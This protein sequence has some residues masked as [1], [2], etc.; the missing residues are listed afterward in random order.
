MRNRLRRLSVVWFCSLGL[1]AGLGLLGGLSG[2][3][4]AGTSDEATDLWWRFESGPGGEPVG[5]AALASTGPTADH[6]QGM[7]AENRALELDGRGAYIRVPDDGR[8]GTLKFRQGDPITLEAW[9]RSDAVASGRNVYIVGKGRTHE[10]EARDNQNYALRLRG[11]G[12]QARLS[13]LFRSQGD[14][15]NGSDWHRWTSQSGFTPDGTW[16]HVAVSYRF[17]DPES[18]RGFIDGQRVGGSWDMG[19]ATD[20]PP[21]VDDDALWIG[22]SM[23]GSGSSSFRGGIDDLVIARRIVPE[24]ELLSRRIPIVRPPTAPPSGIPAD[25]VL[26]T[27]HEGVSDAS[28][29]HGLGDAEETWRQSAFGLVSIP[30]PYARGG[31]RRDWDGAVLVTAMAEIDLPDEPL[32]WMLRAGGLSRL[33]IGET[34]VAETP[35]HLKNTGGHSEV[36]PYPYDDPWLRPARPGHRE[37]VVTHTSAP[38]PTLVTLQTVIGGPNLRPE[39]GEILVAVRPQGQTEWQVLSTAATIPLTDPAWETFAW[40]QRDQ[41]RRIDDRRRRDAASADDDYWDRRHQA[42]RRFVESLP[43]L[44]IPEVPGG[45]AGDD[46]AGRRVAGG[47]PIDAFIGAGLREAGLEPTP[48]SEDGPFLRRVYLDCVGVPPDEGEIARFEQLSGDRDARRSAV[49]E[50]LLDDPRTADHWT[51]YWL[52]V[53]AENPSILKPTLNNT[54]PFRWYIHDAM[55]DNVPIDRWV[56]DL[57]R[58]EGSVLGG[59]PA[60]FAMATE[61]DVPMAA[62]AH[63]LATAFLGVNMKCARCHDAPYHDWTQGDLFSLAAM[64]EREP[65]RIPASSSVPDGFFAG[66][67]DG[68]SLITL[69]VRPGDE[70]PPAWPLAAETGATPL[71]AWLSDRD[72]SSRERLAAHLTRPE[73][74]RFAEVIVNRLWARLIGEGLVEPLEDWDGARPSHPELL[75][76]LA[77]ELTSS[78]YDVRHVLGIILRSRLY[79]REATDRAITMRAESR[80]FAAPRRR[81][82][83]AEQVV[84]SMHAAVGRRMRVDDL[85]FDPEGRQRPNVFLNL[86]SPRRAWQLT[87]LSNERDR[88]SL[89]LPR[90]AAVTECLE[91]FGWSGSRQEPINRR[92]DEPNV[93]Q[94]GVLAGGALSIQLTRLTDDDALTEICLQADSAEGLVETLFLRFL[95]RPPTATE[96][97]LF[98]GLV[99]DGFDSR[100]LDTPI[101]PQTPPREPAVSWANHLSSEANNI[102]IREGERLLQGPDPTGR[103]APGWRQRLEDVAWALMNTPEFQYLP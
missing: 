88:P 92:S 37:R 70:I 100:V 86:G 76:Y 4:A 77:R 87:S 12:G 30:T 93:I 56:T 10:G 62:K 65:I 85:T 91:A 96:R 64:L 2:G 3:M 102:R 22:S 94:P 9:V 25:A 63:V 98:V 31:V 53:L 6:F 1:L 42:A 48:V 5:G 8:R 51:A 17:G 68:V 69:S 57:V 78:G 75:D 23:G 101:P 34:V 32:E 14:E 90:A 29:P 50:R 24:E 72:D 58:M 11:M 38:G 59:G 67:S 81:R 61:N 97:Q 43:P 28:W 84:D 18:L 27:L 74:R 44:E 66:E 36:E 26:M 21:V 54:G 16:H 19:G 46:T 39:A 103:L 89:S 99:G 71:E 82:M 79:Q 20:R 55:R 83:T 45:G 80:H 13:F 60:G 15:A 95:T 40:S 49:I 7:P 41:M 73:N 52:D 47:N 33:W 35:P